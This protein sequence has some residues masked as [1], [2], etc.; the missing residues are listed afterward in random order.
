MNF[1]WRDCGYTNNNAKH[2]RD[3]NYDVY[4]S[5]TR[6]SRKPKEEKWAIYDITLTF[7][8]DA[9]KAI[10]RWDYAAAQIS[11]ILP[12]SQAIGIKFFTAKEAA[13]NKKTRNLSFNSD[14]KSCVIRF[15]VLGKNEYSTINDRWDK[16]FYDMYSDIDSD[17]YYIKAVL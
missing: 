17:C 9:F 1:V 5:L 8:R 14:G 6:S 4:L 16:K 10:K 13:H 3:T 2:G 12:N 7:R 15:P 11:Q